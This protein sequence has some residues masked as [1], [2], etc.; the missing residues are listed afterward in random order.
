MSL[1]D[2]VKGPPPDLKG[3]TSFTPYSGF[4]PA[5]YHSKIGHRGLFFEPLLKNAQITNK[6]NH[7]VQYSNRAT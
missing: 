7:C 3:K 1:W 6:L 2:T 5:S 4:T